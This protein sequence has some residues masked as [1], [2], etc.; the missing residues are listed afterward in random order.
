MSDTQLSDRVNNDIK[1]SMK[2]GQKERLDALRMLKA[3]FIENRTSPKPKPE[4]D[5]LTAYYKSLKD[6][7][8]NFPEGAPQRAQVAAELKHL[9]P[10]MPAQLDE[11][12]VRQ[13]VKDIIKGLA[14]A[15]KPNMGGVMKELTPKIKGQF[16][17]KRANEIVG[18]ELKN[19]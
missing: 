12:A 19:A 6:S 13:M 8:Q 5:V 4:L 9:D 1:E 16:D 17:G 18:E 3:K 14:A 10:Y 11:T 15:G 7:S 2:S